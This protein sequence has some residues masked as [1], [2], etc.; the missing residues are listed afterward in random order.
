MHMSL[1][2]FLPSRFTN[3]NFYASL[4]L[5]VLAAYLLHLIFLDL[6]TAVIIE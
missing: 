1:K 4:M 2:R 5:I 3:L 6:A